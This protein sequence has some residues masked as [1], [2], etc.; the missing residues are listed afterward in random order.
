[1]K[2]KS[3][4]LR[5]QSSKEKQTGRAIVADRKSKELLKTGS[6][7]IIYWLSRY[8]FLLGFISRVFLLRQIWI[9]KYSIKYSTVDCK[10]LLFLQDFFFRLKPKQ[11][12]NAN[13]ADCLKKHLETHKTKQIIWWNIWRNIW[14]SRKTRLLCQ[15]TER[16]CPLNF[17][18]EYKIT[19]FLV[20]L[21]W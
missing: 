6:D 15:K 12:K 13:I 4:S 2:L 3:T 7:N 19:N 14:R 11:Y 10:Y 8:S 1:M 18:L 20:S 16:C 9:V 17:Q 5:E 21:T